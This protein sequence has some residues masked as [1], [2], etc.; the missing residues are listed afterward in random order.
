[1]AFDVEKEIKIFLIAGLIVLLVYGVWFFISP[2]SYRAL[3]GGGRYF[4]PVADRM[5]GGIFI[6]WAII[7]LRLIKISD[8]WEKLEEWVLFTAIA[9]ILITIAQII[10]II[11]YNVLNI[12]TI[13][14]IIITIFFAIVAIHIFIQKR[15]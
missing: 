11:M 13:I 15:K 3:M 9:E 14:A 1:M 2:E 12:G 5:I 6:A 4:N 7:A 10:G 8:N